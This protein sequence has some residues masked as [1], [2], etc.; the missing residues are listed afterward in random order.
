[1]RD[2]KKQNR[3]LEMKQRKE[4]K[5]FVNK[6]LRNM[7]VKHYSFLTFIKRGREDVERTGMTGPPMR[8]S[9][10]NQG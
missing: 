6:I 2:K 10:L 9:G 3:R 4:R 1:M 5:M 7:G 8:H